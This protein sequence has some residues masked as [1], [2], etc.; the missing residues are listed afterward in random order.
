[1]KR[2]LSFLFLLT[3]SFSCLATTTIYINDDMD[4][5]EE[6]NANL[7]I[8]NEVPDGELVHVYINSRGGRVDVLYA[9]TKV[10]LQKRL[11]TIAHVDTFAA[12]AAAVLTCQCKYKNISDSAVLM[13]HMFYTTA[14]DGSK[15]R[16]SMLDRHDAANLMRVFCGPILTP[17]D[18]RKMEN[19]DKDVWLTGYDINKRLNV[20]GA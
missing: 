10:F 18:L 5:D 4:W 9:Y 11:N 16:I 3:L 12:S 15:Q 13:F 17:A 14:A 6:T 7:K 2:I 1:M 20:T 19:D 8:L